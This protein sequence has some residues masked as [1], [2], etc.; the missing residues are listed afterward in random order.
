MRAGGTLGAV[1]ILK[2]VE[3]DL[4]L[5]M[6]AVEPLGIS[7]RTRRCSEHDCRCVICLHRYADVM[8]NVRR[9]HNMAHI[10]VAEYPVVSRTLCCHQ[11][12]SCEPEPSSF[13][14]YSDRKWR[15]DDAGRQLLGRTFCC[16]EDQLS[17]YVCKSGATASW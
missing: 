3:M 9:L 13:A 14:G 1:C 12:F 15:M 7:R 17:S 16:C 8:V 4:D 5:N 11:L 10:K 2:H 6:Y